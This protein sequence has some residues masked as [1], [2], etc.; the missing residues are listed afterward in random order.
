M[1]CLSCIQSYKYYKRSTNCL[2]CPSYV[3]YEQTGC[4]DKV[5]EGYFVD[6]DFL[7]TIG[8]CHKNCKT[9]DDYE[10]YWSMNC[11]ECKYKNPKY[12]PTYEGDCPDEDYVDYEEEDYSE[13][14]YLGGEC[15]RDK[16]ILRDKKDCSDE[17]CSEVDYNTK[18]C[19]IANLVVKE[20]WLNKFHNFG[21]IDVSYAS[22]ELGLNNETFLFAQSQ[23][24]GNREKYLYAFD[25]KGEGLFQ[26]ESSVNQKYSFKKIEFNYDDYVDS[27]KYVRDINNKK[28][29]LLSTQ[30]GKEMYIFDF[31]KKNP[32]S[33]VLNFDKSAYSTD[34][35]FQI[36]DDTFTYFT[37]FISCIYDD[38]SDNCYIIMRK[39]TIE[40]NAI[41]VIKEVQGNIKVSSKNKLTCLFTEFDF[42]QCTYTTQEKIDSKF[43]YNHVIGF[44]DEETFEFIDSFT[45]KENFNTDSPFDSMI[46]LK[47]N[48]N[49]FVI[50]YSNSTN[51]ISVLLK[52]IG[53]NIDYSE[54]V[55]TDYIKEIPY[56]ELNKDSLYTFRGAKSDRNSL[57]KLNDNK[58][59][60]LLNSFKSSYV[61]SN[62][63]KGIVI[64]IFNIYNDNKNI[65]V[66]HYTIN[67]NLYN[68]FVE[69]D[70]RPY[71]LNDFFGIVVELSDRSI[72]RAS[73]FTFGYVNATSVE[74]D[75]TFIAKDASESK[76]LKISEFI[77][78]IENNLFGFTFLGVKIL[79]LPDE[80]KSGYFINA[81]NESKIKVDDVLSINTELKFKVNKNYKNDIYNIVF[82]GLIQE[83]DYKTMNKF[84]EKLESFPAENI[85]SEE[86]FYNPKIIMGK[87]LNYS[88]I[89]GDFKICY[90]NCKTC[91]DTSFNEDDQKCTECKGDYYFKEGT[92]NCFNAIDE[93]YYFNK[94][95]RVFSPCYKDCL[96]CSNKETN[97]TYM[98]CL[99]CS[100]NF[101]YYS[102]TTNCLKCEKY[103]N[104]LQTECIN[105]IPDGYFLSDEKSGIIDKCHNLCKTCDKASQVTNNIVHM[106]CRECLYTNI[107]FKPQFEGNCPETEYK[108]NGKIE[109]NS[110]KS[111]TA[112][113]VII[114]IVV[115]LIV[116]VIAFLLYRKM[117]SKDIDYKNFNG[118]VISMDEE[119]AIN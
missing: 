45:L 53:Y 23:Q 10:D 14:E 107:N 36:D 62:Q 67:F 70:I 13:E 93:H 46:S 11:I 28:E 20:Q 12:I 110:S 95:R 75:K 2:K 18:R 114:I 42:V 6:D 74:V 9:C 88:F 61:S 119:G 50:A 49:I 26:N 104:Y 7:G 47:E 115:I 52:R 16:P 56:I 92:K 89:L 65:N 116:L 64:Y 69:G 5:P 109:D 96:T 57:F 81:K 30:F 111:N 37:D 78:G 43:V 72:S 63:A 19:I 32:T 15:P 77:T 27:V 17:Y 94:E 106:N 38:P 118:K 48:E 40:N 82:A 24:K 76:I 73:F 3:N 33:K 1:N 102:K 105:T 8:K 35:I 25:S 98:N 60:L 97:S 100:N 59:A 31:S 71:L 90:K 103:I 80:N 51:S 113:V 117:K 21:N 86:Q 22:A 34:T 85:I 108:D 91:E 79:E 84:S 39:F 68:E 112:L 66:R 41:N 54:I 4:I 44:Y 55:M 87:K 58:F 101:N 99:S 83:P 29:Y